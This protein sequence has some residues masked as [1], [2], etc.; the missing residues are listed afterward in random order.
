[1]PLAAPDYFAGSIDPIRGAH[2]LFT[3]AGWIRRR[4]NEIIAEVDLDPVKL[5]GLAGHCFSFRQEADKWIKGVDFDAV[6]EELV[7]LTQAAGVANS[8][9]T[10]AEINDD[11]KR[12]YAEA[13]TFLVWATANL[14]QV[15][16]QVQNATVTVN[17]TWPSTDF[18]VRVPKLAAIATRVQALRSVF[19]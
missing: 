17:R 1:M 18:M 14:P 13:G 2:A 11:Y 9:K 6:R 12:L 10:V 5:Y 16:Q 15:G 19:L 7:R 8:V 4:C 3:E